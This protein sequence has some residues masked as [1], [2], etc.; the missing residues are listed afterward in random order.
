MNK[1]PLSCNSYQLTRDRKK[2]KREMKKFLQIIGAVLLLMVVTACGEQSDKAASSDSNKAKDT[3]TIGYQKGNSLHIL[4]SLGYLD[5]VFEEQGITVEWK[6]LA[7]GGLLLEALNAGSI[8]FGH[9]ADANAVFAQ[10]SGMPLVYV[11]SAFPN[12][13]G[14]AIIV[15]D[16]ADIEKASDLEGKTVAIGKGWNSHYLLMKALQKEG[17]TSEDVNFAYVKDASEG[18]AVI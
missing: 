3:V 16:D 17:L 4:K 11:A 2:G 18:R 14:L 9:A 7:T 1:P 8:D 10:A 15:H 5:E 12:P 6:E 13:E